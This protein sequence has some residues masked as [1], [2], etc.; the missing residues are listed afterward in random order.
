MQ[1]TPQA[2]IPEDHDAA[3]A[4]AK[5]IADRLAT[6]ESL[7][8]FEAAVAKIKVSGDTF[9]Q[10]TKQEGILYPNISDLYKEWLASADRIP[11]DITV[12]AKETTAK[13][14]NGKETTTLDGYYVIYFKEKNDNRGKMGNVRH[15]LI[16]S[17]DDPAAAELKA[18]EL[19]EQWKSGTKT[20]ESFVELVK[21]YSDDSGSV[22]T[23][24]LYENIHFGS[25]YVKE[26]EAWAID[27]VRLMGDAEIIQTE[28][29]Y[30][31]MYFVGHS[32]QSYREQII[33][34]KLRTE[35]LNAWYSELI[36]KHPVTA[37]NTDDL[38][39]ERSFNELL[40]FEL[41]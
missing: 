12:V 1:D 24:G 39:L 25:P 4:A 19:L 10:V 18:N 11:G 16:A 21:T 26:F 23:G 36:S 2:I 20:E 35:D 27:P 22:L 28:F 6:S 32:Q 30:H 34:E 41:T 15:L 17:G 8:A 9:H 33:C 31:I 14:A 3:L 38:P 37:A 5:E 40:G 29:G 7:E 13:D